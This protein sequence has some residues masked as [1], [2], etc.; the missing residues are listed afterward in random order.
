MLGEESSDSSEDDEDWELSASRAARLAAK[1]KRSL[2]TQ[3]RRSAATRAATT[4]TMTTVAP[5]PTAT[6]QTLFG[7][8]EE[9]EEANLPCQRNQLEVEKEILEET[10]E[11]ESP[12][13]ISRVEE[14][15]GDAVVEE[16]EPQRWASLS[17]VRSMSAGLVRPFKIRRTHEPEPQQRPQ[18]QQLQ[19]QQQLFHPSTTTTTTTERRFPLIERYQTRRF[20]D[21]MGERETLEFGQFVA[22]CMQWIK[23]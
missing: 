8:D 17:L 5:L 11:P 6:T 1:P 15:S 2:E 21:W 7:D 18:Q 10:A 4:T 13:E 22:E 19:Q 23:K 3:T 16:E 12:P 14:T 9:E 20:S